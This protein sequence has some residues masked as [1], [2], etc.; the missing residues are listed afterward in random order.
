M[1]DAP[2]KDCVDAASMLIKNHFKGDEGVVV[3]EAKE[4]GMVVVVT[5][6]RSQEIMTLMIE[7]I[8]RIQKMVNPSTEDVA[9]DLFGL[10]REIPEA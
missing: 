2:P 6:M 4:G 8:E 10:N 1:S 3:Y 7:S 5:D 9:A